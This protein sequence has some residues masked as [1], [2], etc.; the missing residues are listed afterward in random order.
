MRE[1][2][3][4]LLAAETKLVVAMIAVVFVPSGLLTCFGL[5]AISSE[6]AAQ[7]KRFEERCTDV[8]S[9][10]A[11]RLDRLVAR[12]E[13]RAASL[14]DAVMAQP[15]P[16][17]AKERRRELGILLDL[18]GAVAQEQAGL[19]EA[20]LFLLSGR[21]DIVFPSPAG[22]H[23]RVWDQA[24]THFRD[25]RILRNGYLYEFVYK[26]S[27]KAL[28]VY[29]RLLGQFATDPLMR[30]RLLTCIARC[31]AR[32]GERERAIETYRRLVRR[33]PYVRETNGHVF[34]LGARW[35]VVELSRAAAQ[36]GP[37]IDAVLG[38]AEHL[39]TNRAFVDPAEHAFY[40][41]RVLTRL[42]ERAEWL[43]GRPEESRGRE[44]AARLVAKGPAG[45]VVFRDQVLHELKRVLEYAEEYEPRFSPCPVRTSGG[46]HLLFCGFVP[47]PGR[48]G[49][50]GLIGFE[51]RHEQVLKGVLAAA[52]RDAGLLGQVRLAVLD[53]R[54]KPVVAEETA[55]GAE[56]VCDSPV[57]SLPSGWRVAAFPAS[58]YPSARL[59][60]LRIQLY[61]WALA[62]SICIVGT[63][64]FLTARSVS[65]HVRT[66]R[67]RSDFVSRVTHDLK[68]PLTSIR[69]FV[70]TLQMGRVSGEE[71]ARECLEVIARETQKLTALIDRVLDFS[72]LEAGKKQFRFEEVDVPALVESALESA[73]PEIEEAGFALEVRVED[74]LPTVRADGDAIAE[75]LVNLLNNAV[76]YSGAEK[77]IAVRAV[78]RGDEVALE[79]EDR[80]LGIPERER[81]RIFERFYRADDQRVREASGTGLGLALCKQ[82]VEAHGGRIEV[83][84]QVG[85]GS[86]F[87]AI[88]P[89]R[90]RDE[91]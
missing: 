2:W 64:V 11:V 14:R 41:Q 21:G 61:A 31:Q 55:E 24:A 1:F 39:V 6:R 54:G 13:T 3:R 7:E 58:A 81:K 17:S 20:H 46:W 78:R 27:A 80:G 29:E 33:Y 57:R 40:R 71:E 91:A 59:A 36:P 77:W 47:T 70:E 69:M 49:V 82:I 45:F 28:R 23:Q 22:P 72:R 79:V 88:L 62:L 19:E 66:A 34:S 12:L 60:A 43:R 56:W 75:V 5:V 68:T 73:R 42:A 25:E 50:S 65:R 74:G 8:T 26:D 51:L 37:E 10:A 4:S 35:Q 84:S 16:D 48:P 85:V 63:G 76:K 15:A 67:M 86:T 18:A 53:D 30:C 9:S 44:L 32:V 87:S 83:R 38:L 89:R 90:D 52:A